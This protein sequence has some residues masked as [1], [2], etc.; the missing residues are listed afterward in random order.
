[1]NN[2]VVHAQLCGCDRCVS[3]RRG[4]AQHYQVLSKCR[5]GITNAVPVGECDPKQRTCGHIFRV[6][7][8]ADRIVCAGCDL[9]IQG[10]ALAAMGFRRRPAPPEQRAMDLADE[11]QSLAGKLRHA[12]QVRGKLERELA[13]ATG[14]A[15]K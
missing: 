10:I 14:K 2:T 1:M 7:D 4:P 12:D 5:C 9:E 13:E 15:P 8:Y 3:E 11:C 6:D